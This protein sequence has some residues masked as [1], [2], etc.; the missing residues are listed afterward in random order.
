[1]KKNIKLAEAQASLMSRSTGVAYIY[2]FSDEF[3][4]SIANVPNLKVVQ[5][6]SYGKRVK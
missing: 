2:E 6:Y 1:M 4:A 3:R 5:E